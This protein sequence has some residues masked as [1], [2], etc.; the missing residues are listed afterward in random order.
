MIRNVKSIPKSCSAVSSVASYALASVASF[1][2]AAF[3]RQSHGRCGSLAHGVRIRITA[4]NAVS[5]ACED[6]LP[7]ETKDAQG[8]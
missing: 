5:D 6:A 8:H 2:A 1:G 4:A 3:F 7:A